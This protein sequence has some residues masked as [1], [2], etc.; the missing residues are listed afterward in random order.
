[1][2]CSARTRSLVA[3]V[4]STTTRSSTAIG[5]RCRAEIVSVAYS[6][7]AAEVGCSAAST[8]SN[9]MRSMTMVTRS[10][11][12]STSSRGSVRAIIRF[13]RAASAAPIR[14]AG[15]VVIR[16]DTHG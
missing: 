9:R 7:T 1:M 8:A 5:S 13:S 12:S 14:T 10:C 2:R 15:V 6:A 3:N 11:G 4:G 16:T